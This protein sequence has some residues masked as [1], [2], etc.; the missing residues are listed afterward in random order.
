[1]TGLSGGFSA[2]ISELMAFVNSGDGLSDKGQRPF[3]GCIPSID[4]GTYDTCR[5]YCHYCYANVSE[6]AVEKQNQTDQPY[7]RVARAACRELIHNGWFFH[8]EPLPADPSGL[9]F[10]PMGLQIVQ[11]CSITFYSEG[12]YHEE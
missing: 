11:T 1:M 4:I 2:M 7:R 6:T 10:Y 8:R 3:C 5:H 9:F 12:G